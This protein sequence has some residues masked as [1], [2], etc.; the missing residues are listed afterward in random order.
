MTRAKVYENQLMICTLIDV[1]PKMT[2][3]KALART[4][5]MS[6]Q[7]IRGMIHKMSNR[8]LLSEEL[9]DKETCYFFADSQDKRRTLIFMQERIQLLKESENVHS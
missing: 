1:Y 3:P 5:G 6:V 9:Y 8:C 7:S 4:T 2:S